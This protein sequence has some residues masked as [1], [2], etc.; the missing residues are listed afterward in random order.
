[1][2]RKAIVFGIPFLAASLA[3]AQ[4][5]PD[6]RTPSTSAVTAAEAYTHALTPADLHRLLTL[7]EQV[8][9]GEQ[10][11]GRALG[12]VRYQARAEDDFERAEGTFRAV[13]RATGEWLARVP[14]RDRAMHEELQPIRTEAEQQLVAT[15][16]DDASLSLVA[17]RCGHALQLADR[18][19]IV[20][21]GDRQALALRARAELAANVPVFGWFGRTV[22]T[23]VAPQAQPG[24]RAPRARHRP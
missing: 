21:P 9:Q 10:L 18:A 16:L 7:R 6:V 22:P 24:R 4:Q 23:I 12:E 8:A 17:G 5:A 14:V 11:R 13:D 2:I 15:L 20:A 3:W 1:M 19:L